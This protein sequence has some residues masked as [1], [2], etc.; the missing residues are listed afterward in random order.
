MYKIKNPLPENHYLMPKFID[1]QCNKEM[2]EII[3]RSLRNFA[4]LAYPKTPNSECNLVAS[5]ALKNAADEFEK[6]F[7]EHG[8][9]IINRRLR[10]M[11]KTAIIAHYN[12][13]SELENRS[14]TKQC[15]VM[16]KVCKG[17]ITIINNL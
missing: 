11:V 17:D 6:S 3:C 1:I 4:I 15:E 10:A 7:T 12:I 9:G 14:T 8:K 16:L 5:D 13:V 2:Q